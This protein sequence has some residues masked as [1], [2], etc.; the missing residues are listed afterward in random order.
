MRNKNSSI[1]K[2]W[3]E[4]CKPSIYIRSFLLIVLGRVHEITK[5]KTARSIKELFYRPE[6]FCI[7]T[8]VVIGILVLIV[9]IAYLCGGVFVK[10]IK[11]DYNEIMKEY[12]KIMEMEG[13]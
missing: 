8:I 13:D 9:Q 12:K 10:Q 2:I 4:M 6:G 3:N 5:Y 1:M 11:Q 7:D